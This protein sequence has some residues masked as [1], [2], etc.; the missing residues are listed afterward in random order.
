[1][2]P[3]IRCTALDMSGLA[4]QEAHGK[5]EDCTSRLRKVRDCTP[6]I[7]GSLSLRSCYDEHISGV[8]QNASAKK[9]VLH[10]LLRFPP[11][12]LIG[13][14]SEPF[15]G[16]KS[17]RQKQ[18]LKHAVAF[19]QETH[20]GN[21]VFAARLDRDE[22]G[23][24]IVDV[25]ASPKYEKRTKRTMETE[26]GPLWASA[27]KFGKD[28]AAR[29]QAEILRRHPDAKGTRLTSPRMVGIALNSEFRLFIEELCQVTLAPKAEKATAEPDRLEIEGYKR[30]REKELLASRDVEAGRI[31]NEAQAD[32][33]KRDL[34]ELETS[35]QCNEKVA[36][37]LVVMT[38]LL[39][40]LL[41]IP[42]PSKLTFAVDSL[43]RALVD[44]RARR[45]YFGPSLHKAHKC[46]QSPKS[47]NGCSL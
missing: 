18:M 20:G 44:L 8:R 25:F 47:K 16:S 32:Q 26:S 28:L 45:L 11:E 34:L 31:R 39:A 7:A 3:M 38:K 19:I 15:T 24:T 2:K 22:K 12:L 29:H 46:R 4:A 43:E 33:L 40:E 17:D 23:E 9:P 37:R 5:R 10:F 42:I 13:P 6:L 1:M 14:G 27:T 36:K 21:A 30:L 35:A 41:I